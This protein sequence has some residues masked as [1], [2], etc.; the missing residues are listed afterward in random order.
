M[1]L[2]SPW[3]RS[4][5]TLPPLK[6]NC[7]SLVPRKKGP[8]PSGGEKRSGLRCE[9]KLKALSTAFSRQDGDAVKH[10]TESGCT[11]APAWWQTLQFHSE[12]NIQQCGARVSFLSSSFER[13]QGGQEDKDDRISLAALRK[14]TVPSPDTVI[15]KV[16]GWLLMAITSRTPPRKTTVLRSAFCSYR[17]IVCLGVVRRQLH[18]LSIRRERLRVLW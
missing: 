7:C 9:I 5:Q 3:F 8:R 14:E 11:V 12:D 15:I 6:V 4:N 18:C 2:S 17:L 10:L 16:L 13:P 1:I